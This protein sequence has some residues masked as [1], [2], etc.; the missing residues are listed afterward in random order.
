MQRKRKD[1]RER[2]RKFSE[3]PKKEEATPMG[4]AGHRDTQIRCH[5][6]SLPSLFGAG[7]R[8]YVLFLVRLML[9]IRCR[10]RHERKTGPLSDLRS[11]GSHRKNCTLAEIR[12]GFFES[13]SSF[14][15]QP[16]RNKIRALYTLQENHHFPQIQRGHVIS[17]EMMP[18]MLQNTSLRMIGRL[19]KQVQLP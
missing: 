10:R 2:D 12:L 4:W 11:P 16:V 6:Y 17:K 5:F 9:F 1:R 18:V 8:K 7:L 3:T 19:T 13:T 15:M 14:I